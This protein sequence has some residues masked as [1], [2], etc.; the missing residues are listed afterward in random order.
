M[1]KI[2]KISVAL[3][4]AAMLILS[5]GLMF[6]IAQTYNKVKQLAVNELL[7]ETIVHEQNILY[8]TLNQDLLK[9]ANN[10]NIYPFTIYSPS[11]G[12]F[13]YLLSKAPPVFMAQL[14]VSSDNALL[15]PDDITS[16]DGRRISAINWSERSCLYIDNIAK[17]ELTSGFFIYLIAFSFYMS[18]IAAALIFWR[19]GIKK[20]LPWMLILLFFPLFALFIHFIYFGVPKNI[21]RPTPLPTEMEYAEIQ[22]VV[23][24]A[25]QTGMRDCCYGRIFIGTP[26]MF[27]GRF[28]RIKLSDFDYLYIAE[29]ELTPMLDKGA[30]APSGYKNITHVYYP[31]WRNILLVLTCYV[32][33]G[34]GFN[35]V[36]CLILSLGKRIET[37]ASHNNMKNNVL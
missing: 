4:L 37:T 13:V 19:F 20:Y 24:D 8:H 7:Q 32:A 15:K 26:P 12:M 25:Q 9:S 1:K 27:D 30:L 31:L 28:A 36:L 14:F 29:S 5:S 11:L 6:D 2:Y 34:V 23:S 17:D 18:I 3:I 16:F 33:G 10:D 22:T 21:F 35:I